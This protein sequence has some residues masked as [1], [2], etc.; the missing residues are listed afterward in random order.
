[1]NIKHHL[2]KIVIDIVTLCV[3][4]MIELEKKIPAK[5]KWEITAVIP[6]MKIVGVNHRLPILHM[7]KIMVHIYTTG[8]NIHQFGIGYMINPSLQFNKILKK[9]LKH[10]WVIIFLLGQ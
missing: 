5:D 2:I 10:Y 3:G 4:K 1:M 6:L 7:S 8:K 9:K